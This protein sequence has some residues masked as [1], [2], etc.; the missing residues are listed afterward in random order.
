MLCWHIYGFCHPGCHGERTGGLP[1]SP[2][3]IS[4]L[5][6][7][8]YFVLSETTADNHYTVKEKASESVKHPLIK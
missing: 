3:S 4:E 7:A 8:N 5:D 1:V 2:T 6:F